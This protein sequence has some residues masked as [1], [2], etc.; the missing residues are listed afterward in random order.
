MQRERALQRFHG[1]APVAAAQAGDL[2]G[3]LE[4]LGKA[5]APPEVTSDAKTSVRFERLPLFTAA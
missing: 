1:A 4:E 3:A 2:Q 5:A